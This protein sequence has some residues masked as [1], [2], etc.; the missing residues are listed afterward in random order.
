MAESSDVRVVSWPEDEPLKVEHSVGGGTL[1]VRLAVD[2]TP[3]M[4]RVASGDRPLDVAMRLAVNADDPMPLCV[5]ICEPL[6]V[7]SDYIIAIEI[8]DRPVA[9]IRVRGRTRVAP[10]DEGQVGLRQESSA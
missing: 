5:T 9:T 1:P 7:T 10:C 4:A 6:C 8:F 3:I 2:A